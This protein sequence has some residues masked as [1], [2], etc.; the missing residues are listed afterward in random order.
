MLRS[1]VLALAAPANRLAEM[2]KQLCQWDTIIFGMIVGQLND[3]LSHTFVI[4]SADDCL[5]PLYNYVNSTCSMHMMW[6]L[7]KFVSIIGVCDLSRWKVDLFV[8]VNWHIGELACWELTMN[9]WKLCTL[10]LSNHAD[11]MVHSLGGKN[12]K[13]NRICYIKS[14]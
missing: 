6:K 3:E 8:L 14:K 13:F 7:I 9:P 12:S 10:Q 11:K 4:R 1:S 2:N 5:R